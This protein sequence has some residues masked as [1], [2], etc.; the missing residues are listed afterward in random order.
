MGDTSAEIR[1][2]N[3]VASSSINQELDLQTLAEDL[4]VEF[5]P[6][7]FP[8]LVYQV[9]N[10]DATALLFD[11]GKIVCTGADTVGNIHDAFDDTMQVLQELGID[12]PP[13]SDRHR[14]EYR[15]Q[16]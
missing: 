2:E 14:R 9:Q 1:I 8:G 13:E 15:L 10:P 7:E 5:V 12:V 3:V 4:N 6:E 16:C 11:S